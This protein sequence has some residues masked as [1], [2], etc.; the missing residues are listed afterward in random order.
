ML[1][2]SSEVQFENCPSYLVTLLEVVYKGV[3]TRLGDALRLVDMQ[4]H[5]LDNC[6]DIP[7]AQKM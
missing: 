7:T 6:S 1:S 5:K 3:L 4:A 2:R